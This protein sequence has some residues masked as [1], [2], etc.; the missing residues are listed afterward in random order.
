[1]KKHFATLAAPFALALAPVPAFA[2]AE[3]Y[4][5]AE[6]FDGAFLSALGAM[7]TAEELTEDQ[8]ALLPLASTVV[9]KLLPEGAYARVME[10]TMQGIFKPLMGMMPDQMSVA[11]MADALGMS[12]EDLAELTEEEQAEVGA[13][14]DPVFA[15]RFGVISDIFSD[16]MKAMADV[17]E[18]GMREGLSRAYASR[19]TRQELE[20]V[21]AF[22]QTP[23]GARYAGESMVI[24]SDPQVTS[25]TMQAMPQ[26]LESMGD[27]EGEMVERMAAFSPPRDF[28]ALTPEERTRLAGLLDISEATLEEH[29]NAAAAEDDMEEAWPEE[30]DSAY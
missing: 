12:E 5:P 8:Q 19:F 23:S 13:M 26:M 2:Q 25:M 18:P 30:D 11:D 24:F 22:F 1:M 14:I 28:D 16:K 4:L 29:M 7:F 27:I 10:E 6:D 20:D 9:G 3:E 15:D 17:I 21:N